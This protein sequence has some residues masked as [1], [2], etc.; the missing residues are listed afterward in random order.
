MKIKLK[1]SFDG[2]PQGSTTDISFK[3]DGDGTPYIWCK[4]NG[5]WVFLY[6]YQFDLVE[7]SNIKSDGNQSGVSL[8][9]L[10]GQDVKFVEF[11]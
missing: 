1:I 3:D 2:L 7:D 8:R 11:K 5:N 10:L 4:I 6:S 9:G